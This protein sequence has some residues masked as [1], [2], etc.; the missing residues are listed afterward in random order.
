VRARRGAL[1]WLLAVGVLVGCGG[2]EADVDPATARP[3]SGAFSAVV[4]RV[5]DGD[6]LVAVRDG[7]RLRVRLIGIDA[8]ESV[9]PEAPVECYGPEAADALARLLPA[10]TAVRGAYEAGEPR[11][12]YGRELWDVWLTDGRFVQ[13]ELVSTGAAR[14]RTYQPHDRYADLLA[15]LGEQAERR[16][17]G[18]HGACR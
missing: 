8:P 7:A 17:A 13:A 16:G 15:A 3:P 6:T 1:A 2:G 10:G 14:A 5:V 9:Q 12:Q 4:E 11:D 18:L